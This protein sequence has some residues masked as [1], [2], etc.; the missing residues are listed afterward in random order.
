MEIKIIRT[1]SAAVSLF[2]ALAASG[3]G[4]SPSAPL[5]PDQFGAKYKFSATDIPGWAQDPNDSGAYWA[6]TDLIGGAHQDGAAGAYTDRGFVQGMYQSLVGPDPQ[7]ATVWAMDFGTASNAQS[8][9]NWK[10]T[11]QSASIGIPPYDA[12]AALGAS[13]TTGLN[14]FAWDKASYFEVVVQGLGAQ[15][16]AACTECPV[17]KQFLDVLKSKTN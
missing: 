12:S 11:D 7:V 17:A 9:F 13:I 6:G 4:S 8:M 2:L 15:T 10:V 14:V 16:S 5:T 1:L 3:C